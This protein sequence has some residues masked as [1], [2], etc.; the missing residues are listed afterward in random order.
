[1]SKKPQLLCKLLICLCIFTVQHD[2]HIC[3]LLN[4]HR[5][6]GDKQGGASL[7]GTSFRARSGLL[8]SIACFKGPLCQI[9]ELLPLSIQS[10]FC[11]YQKEESGEAG[12]PPSFSTST[13]PCCLPSN[14]LVAFL[15]QSGALGQLT[16]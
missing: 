2:F 9:S 4:P 16:M 6:L 10:L 13:K 7:L 15:H 1:M 3:H 5:S 8:S 12:T 11:C 14:D